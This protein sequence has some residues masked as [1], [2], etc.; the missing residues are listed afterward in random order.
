MKKLLQRIK[1]HYPI[2][3]FLILYF[4]IFAVKL[5][6][7]PAPFY[8]WDESIYAEVGKEMIEKKSLVPLWQY[9]TW[10]DKPPLVPLFYG[11][12]MKATPF[13]QPEISTRIVTLFIATIALYFVYMLYFR[14]TKDPWLATLVVVLTSFT[15]IIL[16]RALVLNFDIFL[17]IGWLGYVL[18]Y[19][20]FWYSLFF[21][22]VAVL[23]KSLLGFYAP[24]IMSLYFFYLFITKQIDRKELIKQARTILI[25]VG[26]MFM[27]YLI[28]LAVYGYDFFNQH[29]Y[30]SHM[31]RV[32]ASIETHFGRRE[33]YITLLYEY[34]GIYSFLSV[35]GVAII[36]VQWYKK[37]LQ[38]KQILYALFLLPWF[39]FLNLTKTKIFWYSHPY[40]PQFAFL[41]LYPVILLKRFN[42][43]LYPMA[44]AFL[45]LSI[46]NFYVIK[47]RVYSV[48]Y[49]TKES[50]HELAMFASSRCSSL[51]MLMEPTERK[52]IADLRSMDLTITT[53]TWWGQHP[54]MVYYFGKK[55][56]FV[57]TLDEFRSALDDRVAGSCI[58]I[59]K[60]DESRIQDVAGLTYLNQFGAVYLYKFEV[61]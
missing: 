42:K 34:F 24:G 51:T 11:V 8:D 31:K 29:I 61:E 49:A 32:T 10:L 33:Y 37:E 16:Q 59:T 7:N 17:L 43:Y 40:I 55:I 19:Q 9:Q 60:E 30:E 47:Q 58:T 2:Y 3:I 14:T 54:S 25:H 22:A 53:T 45:L 1:I 39:L 23:S 44:I 57:Y 15:S 27:W 52:K 46:L 6:Q 56:N 35:F 50:H 13:V 12:I 28:M 38:P 21:L 48:N 5:I 36:L 41:I 4:S 18:F 20:R 26:I